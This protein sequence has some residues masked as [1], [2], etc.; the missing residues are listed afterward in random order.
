MILN[1]C[2]PVVSFLGPKIPPIVFHNHS[3]VMQDV[4]CFR[5]IEKPWCR[6]KKLDECDLMRHAHTLR[7]KDYMVEIWPTWDTWYLSISFEYACGCNHA[8]VHNQVLNVAVNILLHARGP[9]CHPT[10]KAENPISIF[11]PS[12]G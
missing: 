3:H 10:T 2:P 8:Y 4:P 6:Y 9:S 7:P 12:F 5:K 11:V 1:N